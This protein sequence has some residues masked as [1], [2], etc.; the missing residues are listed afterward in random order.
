MINL[1]WSSWHGTSLSNVATLCSV[2]AREICCC[3]TAVSANFIYIARGKLL[4]HVSVMAV[5]LLQ[6]SWSVSVKEFSQYL[7]KSWQT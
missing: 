6:I 5:T 2:G 4:R 7:V 3:V 1:C